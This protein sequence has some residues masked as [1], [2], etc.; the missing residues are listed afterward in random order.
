LLGGVSDL[1]AARLLLGNAAECVEMK[2]R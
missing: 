2:Y 1:S